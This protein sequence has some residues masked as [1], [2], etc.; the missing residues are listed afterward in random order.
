MRTLFIVPKTI[1]MSTPQELVMYLV[2]GTPFGEQ[3]K[4]LLPTWSHSIYVPGC[5]F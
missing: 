2:L 5:T 3:N 4:L 1:G